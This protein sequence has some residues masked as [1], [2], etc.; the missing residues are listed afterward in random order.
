MRESC[1]LHSSRNKRAGSVPRDQLPRQ[2]LANR[3][4]NSSRVR[5]RVFLDTAL[6]EVVADSEDLP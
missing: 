1:Q 5:E 3:K 4:G 2:R 6:S